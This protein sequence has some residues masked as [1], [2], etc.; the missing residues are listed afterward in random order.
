MQLVRSILTVSGL[1]LLSRI[2]GFVRDVLIAATL[3]DSAI[4]DAFW[5]AF[6]FPNFFRRLF[7][8]GAF[9]AAF[10][11]T[12]SRILTREGQ[13]SAYICASQIY[14]VLTVVL[15]TLVIFVELF[16]PLLMYLIVPGWAKEPELFELTT[17]F[18]RITFPYILFISIA[19]LF[20]G[21]LNSMHH[22]A[23]GAAAPIL[24]NLSM[25]L[26]ILFFAQLLATPGHIL[27]WA[28]ALAGIGQ[29]I[30][31]WWETR[32]MCVEVHLQRPRLTEPVKRLLSLMLP[33]SLAAGIVQVNILIGTIFLS[34]LPAG[35]ISYIVYADRLF[36]LPLSLVGVAVSTALLPALAQ[37]LE[38]LQHNEARTTQNRSLEFSLFLILPAA[39]AMF[40][41]AEP[42]ICALFERGAFGRDQ[43][44]KTAAALA[45][46][47]LG[48]PAYVMVKIF[49][50]TFF[51]HHN[52]RIPLH[53]AVLAV[54]TNV[55]LNF[56]LF[57]PLGHVGIA[58][59]TSMASWVNAG[60]LIYQLYK[61]QFLLPDRRLY[62]HLPRFVISCLIMVLA[63]I[64][65]NYVFPVLAYHSAFNRGFFLVLTIIIGSTIYF[66]STL[67][68]KAFSIREIKENLR[69]KVK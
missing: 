11:P 35:S 16:L 1:T 8:E 36:Q 28:V 9:N 67:A 49:S 43:T 2:F 68:L 64:L 4:A 59:A 30:W 66:L 47:S 55:V 40:F 27:S 48:L 38:L 65:C 34:F 20:T 21:I 42:I 13:S 25:I 54:I 52:T 51:A 6:R 62:K 23:V 12:F 41:L 15:V 45:A 24:L 33:A 58:L 61:R 19:A 46:F 44:I 57:I 60:W 39:F 26:A 3:G 32:R 53:A 29:M 56:I 5:V 31:V 50:T 7:A 10:V 22:F 37:Q 69:L 14:S 63:L 18:I 17:S